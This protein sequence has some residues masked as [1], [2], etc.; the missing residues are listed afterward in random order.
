MYLHVCVS[1]GVGVCVGVCVCVCACVGVWVGLCV[2]VY[3]RVQRCVS[4]SKIQKVPDTKFDGFAPERNS[5]LRLLGL[6]R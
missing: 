1:V 2:C 4:V 3:V 5:F 6:I